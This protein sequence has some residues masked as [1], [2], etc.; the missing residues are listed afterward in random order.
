MKQPRPCEV[1]AAVFDIALDTVARDAK[2]TKAAD[3]LGEAN[4]KLKATR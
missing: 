4:P 3:V 2:F 1:V